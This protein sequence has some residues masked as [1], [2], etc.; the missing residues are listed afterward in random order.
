MNKNGFTLVEL[1]ATI[2]VIAIVMGIV[3]PSALKV[4]RDNSDKTYKEYEKMMEEYAL[5]SV[6]KG[7]NV[8]LL[9]ELEELGKVKNE[10]ENGY[11][12]R[13]STQPLEYKA[14]LSCDKYITP[15]YNENI[16]NNSNT[17]N[18]DLA[19]YS[20]IY[21]DDY[22]LLSTDSCQVTNNS[23]VETPSACNI[24][25]N[26][27][28]SKKGYL[29]TGWK[30]SSDNQLHEAGSDY[31]LTSSISMAATWT[32]VWAK[33]LLFNNS[34]TKFACSDIQCAIVELN[35]MKK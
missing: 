17:N 10:C 18:N 7:Q 27:A 33:D 9:S 23:L 28:P 25:L 19:Y 5:I 14:Y 4:S 6:Y 35:K 26:E 11:V 8:I 24:V 22:E 30:S 31:L 12:V 32:E 34:V 13:I 16:I 29:F 2:V 15:N 3:L 21:Y 20:I 1:L